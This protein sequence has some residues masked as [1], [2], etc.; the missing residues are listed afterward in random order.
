MD[1]SQQLK[2]ESKGL[3]PVICGTQYADERA[4]VDANTTFKRDLMER[5]GR[6][7]LTGEESKS[8]PYADKVDNAMI[9]RVEQYELLTD[10]PDSFVAYIGDKLNAGSS[11]N[12]VTTWTGLPIGTAYNGSKWRS[13]THSELTQ[14]T[15]YIGGRTFTGRGQGRGMCVVLRETAQSKRNRAK[16]LAMEVA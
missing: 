15:A 5:E 11:R 3:T 10:T 6:N 12:I 14:Y 16:A 2:T 4:M 7:Y 8:A 9:G 13:G 1:Y